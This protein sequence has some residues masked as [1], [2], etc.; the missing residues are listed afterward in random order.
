MMSTLFHSIRLADSFYSIQYKVIY[1]LH[2]I[3]LRA[4]FRLL[5]HIKHGDKYLPL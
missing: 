2:V 5:N 1:F 4:L 3:S